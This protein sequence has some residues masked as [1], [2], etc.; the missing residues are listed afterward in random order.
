MFDTPG[1]LTRLW[2]FGGLFFV[3]WVLDTEFFRS[4]PGQGGQETP[5][6]NEKTALA[7]VF[8]EQQVLNERPLDATVTRYSKDSIAWDLGFNRY[9]VKAATERADDLP[10]PRPYL[11][12][13][14]WQGGNAHASDSWI[15]QSLEYIQ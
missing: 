11:C 3:F 14:V 12:K 7:Q 13:I 8:C 2:A 1:P 5:I 15:V 4:N 6:H 9:L 10:Q